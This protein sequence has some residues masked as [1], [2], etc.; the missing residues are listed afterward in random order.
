LLY[1]VKSFYTLVFYI[2]QIITH[3]LHAGA[4]NCPSREFVAEEVL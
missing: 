4:V 2:F 3:L 1:V